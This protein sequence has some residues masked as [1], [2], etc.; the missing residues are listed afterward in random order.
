MLPGKIFGDDFFIKTVAEMREGCYNKRMRRRKINQEKRKA[1]TYYYYDKVLVSNCKLN[2]LNSYAGKMKIDS[3]IQLSAQLVE[4]GDAILAAPGKVVPEG[5]FYQ[6]GI[7]GKVTYRVHKDGNLMRAY[8]VDFHWI[9]KTVAD[10]PAAILAVL[11]GKIL[12]KGSLLHARDWA[13]ALL[14]ERGIQESP[15]E[16]VMV[17]EQGSQYTGIIHFYQYELDTGIESRGLMGILA[18]RQGEASDAIVPIEDPELRKKAILE[19]AAGYELLSEDLRQKLR[20]SEI[21]NGISRKLYMASM[22]VM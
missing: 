17:I 21:V 8:A 16:R 10:I 2:S 1:M 3:V 19:N 15:N 14:G 4:E 11:K 5:D 7:G 22:L 12:L 20:E 13:Y 18:L 6:V 9:E